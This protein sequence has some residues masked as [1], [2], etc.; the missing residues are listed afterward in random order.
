M[1]D[2]SDAIKRRLA[3]QELQVKK[4]LQN[5]F[6][7]RDVY[8]KWLEMI[9]TGMIKAIIGPRRAG[10]T[11]LAL[12]LL[13]D[14]NFYYTNFDDELLSRIKAEDMGSVL[15]LLHELFG[16]RNHIILDEIQNIEG[17]ELFVNRL[18]RLEYNVIVTGSN[19]KLLSRELST[20][21]GGRALPL[22]L[23]PFSFKEFARAKDISIG[24]ETDESI[25]LI[26]N[27]LHEYVRIGSYPE[28]VLR[29]PD[30]IRDA[31]YTEIF[32][33]II[34]RDIAQRFMIRNSAGLAALAA[35]ILNQYSARTSL[36]KISR[37]LGLSVPTIQRYLAY[38]EEAYLIISAKKFS[39]KPKEQ[40][41]SYRKYYSIDS[42]LINAKKTTPT[43]DLGRIVEN[44]TAL[45]L[46]RRGKQLYYYMT[47][48]N[49]EV[50][51]LDVEG[52]NVNKVIQVVYD[53]GMIPDREIKSGLAACQELQCSELNIITWNR[54]GKETKQGVGITYIPLWNW[55]ME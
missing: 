28:I 4:I 15:E 27:A 17:W 5:D 45:E 12:M 33:T 25:G 51:F 47:R 19:A 10:K 38:M 31:Y 24:F 32:N 11:V 54:S 29:L 50:D 14:K 22:E 8:P 34:L 53:A 46:R 6:V 16:K 35:I 41:S 2:N 23:L 42:G 7:P 36:S 37:S 13:R 9:S 44:L 3:E 55:L 20:H 21:L 39:Y 52:Q 40:E 18:H 26:K 1:I 43:V 30:G 49:Q 48:N